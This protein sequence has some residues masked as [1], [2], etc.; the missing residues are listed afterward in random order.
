MEIIK[1][2]TRTREELIKEN[3][4][5]SK[6]SQELTTTILEVKEI[7]FSIAGMMG[8]LNDEGTDIN[9]KFWPKDGSE[10]L[11]PIPTVLAAFSD[12]GMQYANTRMIYHSKAKKEQL[13]EEFKKK[14]S[15]VYKVREILNKF[16][17]IHGGP[18][19]ELI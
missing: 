2:D 18:K 10:G 5:L 17:D 3:D 7:V 4:I 13:L 8:M 14:V 6:K 1:E 19:I 9:E 11:S 12:L 15:F 16:S